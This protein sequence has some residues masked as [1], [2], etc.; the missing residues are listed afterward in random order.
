MYRSTHTI[1]GHKPKKESY[2]HS[3]CI[4]S[5]HLFKAQNVVNSFKYYTYTHVR[6]VNHTDQVTFICSHTTY[7]LKNN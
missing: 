2:S 7:S 6:P 5:L 4:R 1:V 3:Q